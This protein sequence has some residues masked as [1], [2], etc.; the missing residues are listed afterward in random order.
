[1]TTRRVECILS[2][3]A[4]KREKTISDS[5]SV[6]EKETQERKRIRIV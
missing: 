4:V 3:A 5:E 6:E 1:M 2:C